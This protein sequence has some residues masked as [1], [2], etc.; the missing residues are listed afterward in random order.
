M[1]GSPNV[2]HS[3]LLRRTLSLEKAPEL[4]EYVLHDIVPG[5]HVGNG[6]YGN[7]TK[8]DYQG[9]LCAGKTLHSILVNAAEGNL[10]EKFVHECK[11]LKD[12]RHP[13]IVQFLGICFL[14]R[15]DLPV[16][17]MEFLPYNLHDLLVEHVRIH[18]SVKLS[19]LRD[20]ARGL[21][22]LH[23]QTPPIVHRDL[24]ARNVL[25][26]SALIAKIAD[27]GVARIID[28]YHLSRT[29]TSIPGAGVYMPPESAQSENALTYSS[30]LDVFSFGVLLL[31]VVT[32]VFPKDPLPATYT[33][34]EELKPR[35]ELQ[36]RQ[37][38][39]NVAEQVTL[40]LL[41]WLSL[42]F[43]ASSVLFHSSYTHA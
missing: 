10:R 40:P 11:L 28:P 35:N 41:F 24:S 16:L 18:M 20:V 9:T 22:Y 42:T 8:L 5:E 37:S 31:F 27:F 12:L 29:L 13:H 26:N 30:K 39:V 3:R 1:A 38:Y 32:Q 2:T 17:V 6:A 36:R 19:L 43:T 23:S 33:E 15:S 25:L 34:G 14:Q 21:R 7:V 4:Q